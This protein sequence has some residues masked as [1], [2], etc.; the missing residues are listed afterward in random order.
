MTDMNDTAIKIEN[1]R[2]QYRLGTIGGGMLTSDLQSW[3]AKVR[4]K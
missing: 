2:K 1:V 3:C 4:G